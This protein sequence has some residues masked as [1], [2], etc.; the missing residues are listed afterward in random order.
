MSSHPQHDDLPITVP[1]PLVAATAPL[2][3]HEGKDFVSASLSDDEK[4]DGGDRAY[5][6]DLEASIDPEQD[7]EEK[8][9]RMS[10]KFNAIRRSRPYVV[11]RD[12]A[13]I[14]LIVSISL[15]H[16]WAL[17]TNASGA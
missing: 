1:S 4:N 8:K 10:N 6:S 16:V 3:D 11:V 17:R 7:E 9:G 12:F 2:D 15:C 14:A 13:C 5:V